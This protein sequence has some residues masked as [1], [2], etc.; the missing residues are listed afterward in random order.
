MDTGPFLYA[1]S[2]YRSP[3]STTASKSRYNRFVTVKLRHKPPGKQNEHRHKIRPKQ[4]MWLS[5]LGLKVGFVGGAGR[6][7][8]PNK[9]FADL[10]LTTW[11]P[12]R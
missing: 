4:C 7:Q 8:P 6:D 1:L 5:Y 9:G 2:I 12:R 11:L 3:A 10:C